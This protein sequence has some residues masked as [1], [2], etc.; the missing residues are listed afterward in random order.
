EGGWDS[1]DYLERS[2]RARIRAT[3]RPVA[4]LLKDLKARGLLESTLVVWAGEFGRSPDNGVRGGQNVAGRD[5]NARGMALWLAG[6]G[7]KARQAVGATDETGAR[8]VE[9]VCPPKDLDR[10]LPH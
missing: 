7:V 1:H 9:G 5:H 2:H 8:A 10:P 3:D 4:A 6:G